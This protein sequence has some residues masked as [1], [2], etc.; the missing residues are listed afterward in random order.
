MTYMESVGVR[1][2]Q[3]HASEVVRRAAAGEVVEITDRGRP[4]ARLVPPAGSVLEG[5]VS[6]GLARAARTPL[7][8]QPPPLPPG[9]GRPR[10]SDLL[11]EARGDER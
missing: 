11:E 4:V 3:Q 7:A 8:E 5:L 10:L 6:A 1:N 9:P 2:L